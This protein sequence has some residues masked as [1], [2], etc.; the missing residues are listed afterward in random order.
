M[1]NDQHQKPR[2][3][4]IH[5][6]IDRED[7]RTLGRKAL[8]DETSI[9]ALVEPVIRRFAERL[10]RSHPDNARVRQSKSHSNKPIPS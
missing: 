3:K 4:A 7:W 2:R 5:V 6:M 10:R 9:Q 8:D 1:A